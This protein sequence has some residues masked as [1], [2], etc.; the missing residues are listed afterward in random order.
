MNKNLWVYPVILVTIL[1]NYG[2]TIKNAPNKKNNSFNN[3]KISNE[4]FPVDVNK[5]MIYDSDFGETALSSTQENGYS[6]YTFKG[7]DFTYRQK[8]IINNEGVFVKE[9]YQKLKVLLVF[10][11]EGTFTYNEPLPRIKFPML[12]GNSWNWKGKEYDDGEINS[13]ELTARVEA[14]ETIQVPAGTFNTIKLVTSIKSSSGTENTVTEWFA[15]NVG[16]IK[17]SAD[18]KGGGLIG[19]LRDLSGL[20]SIEFELAKIETDK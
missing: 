6:I 14:N 20:G 13:I 9:T 3:T 4:Y 2:L 17:M 10:N 12:P 11:K 18:I 15:K 16:L 8:L 19:M 5:T 1:L 7:D